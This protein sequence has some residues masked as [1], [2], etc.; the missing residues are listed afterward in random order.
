MGSFLGICRVWRCRWLSEVVL[1]ELRT[2]GSAVWKALPCFISPFPFFRTF[3]SVVNDLCSLNCTQYKV[4][5]TALKW[6]IWFI[7]SSSTCLAWVTWGAW[8]WP[9]G[10]SDSVSSLWTLHSSNCFY[11]F[12]RVI[13]YIQVDLP[14]KLFFFFNVQRKAVNISRILLTYSPHPSSDYV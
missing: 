2:M 7:G 3:P 6:L 5:S 13:Y 11:H 9:L 4:A 1:L 10:H 8:I 12:S 14:N